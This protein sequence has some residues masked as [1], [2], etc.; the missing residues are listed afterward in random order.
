M[1]E[2]AR[3]DFPQPAARRAARDQGF[4]MGLDLIITGIRETA[5]TSA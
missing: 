3:D 2:Q 1:E 4:A 5:R